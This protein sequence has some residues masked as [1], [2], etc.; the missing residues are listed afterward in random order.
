M[1]FRG[2]IRKVAGAVILRKAAPLLDLRRAVMLY[3]I[4]NVIE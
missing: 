3:V 1:F 4:A 2:T